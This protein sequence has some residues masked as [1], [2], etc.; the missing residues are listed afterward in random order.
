MRFDG[1]EGGGSC[2]RIRVKEDIASETGRD[3]GAYSKGGN[4]ARGESLCI[5]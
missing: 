4:D 1:C 2:D 3:S 5:G